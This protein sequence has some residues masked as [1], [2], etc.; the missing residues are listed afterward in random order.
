MISRSITSLV[1]TSNMDCSIVNQEAGDDQ[2]NVLGASISLGM[3][4]GEAERQSEKK[5]PLKFQLTIV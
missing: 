1:V 5:I 2:E 4:A 3:Q